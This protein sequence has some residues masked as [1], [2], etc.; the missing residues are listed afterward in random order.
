MDEFN[1]TADPADEA[2]ALA[3]QRLA[4]H[5][6]RERSARNWSM[7]DLAERAGLTAPPCLRRVRA[8]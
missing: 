4:R 8:L 1:G 5:I 6:H 2:G 3:A 7:A